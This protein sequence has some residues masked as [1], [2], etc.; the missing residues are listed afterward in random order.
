MRQCNTFILLKKER[1]EKKKNSK[2]LKK[3]RPSSIQCTGGVAAMTDG[4]LLFLMLA[5]VSQI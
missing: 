1:K 4:N 3:K 5:I 2:A